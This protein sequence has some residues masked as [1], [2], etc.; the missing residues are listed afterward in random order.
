MKIQ[1]ELSPGDRSLLAEAIDGFVPSVVVDIHAHVM[2]PRSY[3]PTTLGEH[4]NGR[5]I[6]V[7]EYRQA[8]E[9]LL[10]GERVREALLFPFPARDHD[11]TAIDE[12]LYAQIAARPDSFRAHAL[13][14]VAPG[15]DPSLIAEAM[16]AGR[17][18]GLKPYHFY[19]W[20]G[21]TSQVGVEDFAPEWMWQLCDTHGGVLMLHL[22]RDESVS[23][24]GNR[25]ALLRLTA[26]YPRCQAVLAHVARSFNHRTSRGLRALADRPNV[27]IDTSAIT[28]SEGL[29]AAL[30][31]LGPGK[32]LYG[33]DYPVSHLR[34]RCVTA[35]NQFHWFYA[36]DT[37]PSAMTLVGIE[38]LLALRSACAQVGISPNEVQGIFRDNAWSLLGKARSS[39]G[40]AKLSVNQV[41]Q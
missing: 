12:W 4:L 17:C 33:S 39:S 35:G 26:K 2:E 22:M 40:S 32:V 20:P 24:Q 30:E 29:R 16:T 15:D 10:P 9:L 21:D 25:E 13:A 41:S 8:M 11:R 6:G 34:G 7:A 18:I 36:D 27:W 19:A 14:I 1:T 38:S 5:T 3:A 23:D 37:K 28:E 31:L